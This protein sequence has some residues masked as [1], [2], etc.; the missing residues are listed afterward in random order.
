MMMII[1][2]MMMIIILFV[3]AGATKHAGD[4]VLQQLLYRTVEAS[5]SLTESARNGFAAHIRA[6]VRV[7]MFSSQ[8]LSCTLQF[9]NTCFP[10]ITTNKNRLHINVEQNIFSMCIDCIWV[11]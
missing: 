5:A 9:N 10:P 3:D 7:I 4:Y 11:M 8:L 1:I 6:Y 2:M